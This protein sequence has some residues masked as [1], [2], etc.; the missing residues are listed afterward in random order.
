LGGFLFR[1]INCAMT[2]VPLNEASHHKVTDCDKLTVV[3]FIKPLKILTY[4]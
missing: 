1:W 2:F 4:A 3:N